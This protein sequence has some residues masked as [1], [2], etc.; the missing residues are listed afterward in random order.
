MNLEEIKNKQVQL[1]IQ[2]LDVLQDS[3]ATIEYIAGKR[4]KKEEEYP[5]IVSNGIL[6]QIARQ[7][8]RTERLIKDLHNNYHILNT[9]TFIQDEIAIFAFDTEQ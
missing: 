6:E 3:E 8:A 4:D 2:L 9:H 7:Q 5:E 1:N